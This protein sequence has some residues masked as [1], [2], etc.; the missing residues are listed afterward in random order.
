MIRYYSKC[1]SMVDQT[2]GAIPLTFD[3]GGISVASIS[4]SSTV[5]GASGLSNVVTFAFTPGTHL[6]T[7]KG[8]IAFRRTGALTWYN[9]GRTR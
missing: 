6:A 2:A 3:A 4:T 9:A 5:V 7:V 8:A 1:S